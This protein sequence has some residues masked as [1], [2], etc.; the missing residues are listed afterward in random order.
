MTHSDISYDMQCDAACYRTWRYLITNCDELSCTRRNSSTQFVAKLAIE[1]SWTHLHFQPVSSRFV[2]ILWHEMGGFIS[3]TTSV[4]WL[5]SFCTYLFIFIMQ[6]PYFLTYV[7]W[8][9]ALTK[10]A[11]MRSYVSTPNFRILHRVP[12]ESFS[13]QNIA[14]IL[15]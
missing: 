3:W 1:P 7:L 15:R 11:E 10:S 8:I 9:E 2:L 14:F 5:Y 13:L 4:Y 6:T 12:L